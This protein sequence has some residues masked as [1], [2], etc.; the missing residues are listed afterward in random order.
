MSIDRH[1]PQLAG[2]GAV[3]RHQE[4][5]A[6]VIEDFE[7]LGRNLAHKGEATFVVAL[8]AQSTHP[9]LVAAAWRGRREVLDQDD[10]A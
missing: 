2:A 7:N 1:W 8:A 10:T 6:A 9:V 3:A 5:S 4:P